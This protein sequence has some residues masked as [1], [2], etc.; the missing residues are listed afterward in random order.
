MVLKG[1]ATE[2]V[3]IWTLIVQISLESGVVPSDW[4][5][6]NVAPVYKKDPKYNPE[7]YRPISLTCMC[8]KLRTY[9]S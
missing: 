8:C 2:I 7:N 4:K 9:C 3:P 5:A 6:S 1:L